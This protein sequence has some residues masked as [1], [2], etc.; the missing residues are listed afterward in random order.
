MIYNLYIFNKYCECIFYAEWNL[1]TPEKQNANTK[2]QNLNQRDSSQLQRTGEGFVTSP[3]N[4]KLTVDDSRKTPFSLLNSSLGTFSPLGNV[5]AG[6]KFIKSS[7][8]PISQDQF[9][10]G[11]GTATENAKSLQKQLEKEE[12]NRKD[13]TKTFNIVDA[14]KIKSVSNTNPLLEEAK[15]VYGTVY[16]IRNIVNKLKGSDR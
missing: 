9:K 2:K 16:S 7:K 8:S 12:S 13:S 10:D 11:S 15:L 14:W 3:V 6:E 5:L 4:D 1:K